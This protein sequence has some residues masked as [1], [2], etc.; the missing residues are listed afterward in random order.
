[1][2]NFTTLVAIFLAALIVPTS[3]FALQNPGQGNNVNPQDIALKYI[4][5]GPTFSF[6]G[7]TTTLKVTDVII[8]KSNPSQYTV[9][10][11]FQCLHGGYGDRTDQIITQAIT[12]H[13]AVV[14]VVDGKVIS[15]VIDG[16]WNEATQRPVTNDDMKTTIEAIALNWLVNAPT[17]KFDGVKGSAKVVDSWLAM[18][19]VAPSFWGVTIEFDC[20]QAGYGDR[21][22]QMLAQVITHH[23]ANIHVTESAVNFAVIDDTW[24]EA[25]QVELTP[26]SNILTPEQARDIAFNYVIQKYGIDNSLP[27][28]WM[29]ENLNPT[30]LVGSQTT[31]YTSGDWVITVK[32]AVVW[33]PMY[34]VTVENGSTISWTGSV[35]QSGSVQS[36]EPANP[37]VPQ[38][39]YTPDIARKMCID[40]LLANHPEVMA[41]LPTEWV[42]TNLVPQNLVGITKVQYT[43]GGWTITVS[44]P[45][46][47]KP[48]HTVSINYTGPEGS[49]TWEGTL[50][51]GG[52]I[53]EISFS[54]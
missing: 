33:K 1:M 2:R 32:Y 49:F 7:I 29:I 28:D 6:N 15:A 11:G 48:T 39:I 13:T 44:A 52:P 5:D 30:G 31:R 50:P 38:L 43:A 26:V 10:V 54:K 35:D 3:I 27:S 17:F 34:N 14:T 9:M 23:V 16:A 4:K 24:D 18:T 8:N 19:F 47:W 25:K 41:Q 37:N 36:G 46:V 45:V 21:S 20:L 51:Q 53:N 42:E 12:P 22:D 40:Y